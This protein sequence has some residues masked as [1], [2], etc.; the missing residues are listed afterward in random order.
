MKLNIVKGYVYI[1]LAALFIVAGV[2]LLLT[3][4]KNTGDLWFGQNLVASV[5]AI[6]VA[7][8]VYGAV[9]VFIV[10]LL[11]HGIGDL[12]QGRRDQKLDDLDKQS[13]TVGQHSS[14]DS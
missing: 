10:K 14:D 2:V 8:A 4:A 3:N 6:M 11:F 1:I 12:R 13:R 9:M 7:S 5:G